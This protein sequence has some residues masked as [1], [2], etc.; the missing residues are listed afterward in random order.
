MAN[1]NKLDDSSEDRVTGIDV[2]EGELVI[3]R[4]DGE[5]SRYPLG[6]GSNAPVVGTASELA[7]DN[8]T[9]D[10]GQI[11]LES[12]TGRFTIGTGEDAW[13]DS[14]KYYP[15]SGIELASAVDTEHRDFDNVTQDY[16]NLAIGPFTVPEGM[17]AYVHALIPSCGITVDGTTGQFSLVHGAGSS[18]EEGTPFDEANSYLFGPGAVN[19]AMDKKLVGRIG[20]GTHTVK[21]QVFDSSSPG[22]SYANFLGASR[23]HLWAE[24]K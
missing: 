22:Y 11:V 6:N 21:I 20:E 5:E 7:S 10:A 9:P 18:E 19:G 8:P 13:A 3:R 2:V 12:D 23:A 17:V 1:E 15:V 4:L 14:I 16:P 24:L